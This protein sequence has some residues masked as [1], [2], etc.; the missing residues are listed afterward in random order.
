MH[1]ELSQRLPASNPCGCIDRPGEPPIHT[2]VRFNSIQVIEDVP[3]TDGTTFQWSY[4][5]PCGLLSMLVSESVALASV[6]E[7]AKLKGPSSPL[8]PWSLVLAWDEFCPGNKLQID[9]SRKCM[10]L[11]FTF[12][13]LG[14]AAISDG[15]AW[16]TPVVVRTK[17]LKEVVGGWPNLLRRFLRRI[18]LGPSGLATSGFPLLLPDGT[19]LPLFAKLS[20]LMS[21]GDGLRSGLDWRGHASLK[22]CFRHF[23]VWKK[24][25]DRNLTSACFQQ[26]FLAV[27]RCIAVRASRLV[28][29][30]VW[31]VPRAASMQCPGA[32]SVAVPSSGLPLR[33]TITERVTAW[34]HHIC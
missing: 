11:S 19:S 18:L 8:R 4:A 24:D 1:K 3:L 30:Y 28:L 29:Q 2:R 6:F 33:C 25:S 10:V 34:V 20:N 9:P 26:A 5:D 21:D 31:G 22:P 17:I 27:A 14:Q 13:Q 16:V 32:T 15:L 23:N 7:A 12:V